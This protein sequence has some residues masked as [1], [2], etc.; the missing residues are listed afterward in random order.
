MGFACWQ[1]KVSW[2]TLSRFKL[3]LA[4]A[5]RCCYFVPARPHP[6]AYVAPHHAP[7]HCP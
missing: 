5:A 1:H 3:S 6:I 4:A 2:S 7:L